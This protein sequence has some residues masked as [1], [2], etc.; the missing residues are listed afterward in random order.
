MEPLVPSFLWV[1]DPH[2]NFL[3]ASA[4]G[5]F[6]HRLA[7]YPKVV[8][9]VITGD[10][11]E[12]RDFSKY[13]QE[14][15]QDRNVYFVLGN[16]DFYGDSIAA[17]RG[18]ARSRP[19]YLEWRNEPVRLSDTACLVGVDGWYDFKEGAG[20]GT[21]LRMSDWELITDFKDKP[22]PSIAKMSALL[23][24]QS[25]KLALKKLELAFAKYK[26]VYLATHV[27]PFLGA[28]LSPRRLPSDEDWAPV[29]VN[30]ALG[31]ALR[32]IRSDSSVHV[33]CGHTHTEA[34]MVVSV[35]GVPNRG[36]LWVSAGRAN[37]GEVF[38][39]EFHLP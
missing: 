12:S 6:K 26:T 5:Y 13:L 18:H 35:S 11:A 31:E 17:T 15:E 39:K 27:P 20:A 24:R 29:M 3:G 36:D 22:M 8:P 16:H 7:F 10:I 28:S 30:T 38:I 2:F 23:A 14:L 25:A 34:C 21:Q 4:W 1:T 32:F 37:Y 9:L 33:L 19:G